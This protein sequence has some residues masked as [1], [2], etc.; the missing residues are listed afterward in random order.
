[1]SWPRS[2]SCRRCCTPSSSASE[3]TVL[4]L[5][6]RRQPPRL[7]RGA[8]AASGTLPLAGCGAAVP[9]WL[10]DL[11]VPESVAAELGPRLPRDLAA[12]R[13]PCATPACSAGWRRSAS[14]SSPPAP[15]PGRSGGSSCS[16]R[17][18]ATRSRC[19]AATSAS[20]PACSRSRPTRRSSRPCS[21]TRSATSTPA[22]P[23][24]G[25]WP[26][27]RWPWPCASAPRSWR[28]ATPT[29]P[30][31]LV[32]AL[33][34]TAADLGLIR[35][36]SRGQ[37][38]QA[39]ELGLRYMARAGYDPAASIAFWQRMSPWTAATAAVAGLPLDPSCGRAADRAAG[40]A[41]AER[42]QRLSAS[43][44]SSPGPRRPGAGPRSAA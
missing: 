37:E 38:L 3:P 22:T 36:F 4:P 31:D 29:I 17:R 1:M 18:G 40:G 41:A 12:D 35:P 44:E 7:P 6:Q 43:K 11:L 24:S 13:R 42:G 2:R 27:T 19:R 14:G 21:A 16:T 9:D 23:P 8:A 20:S 25:S 26:R 10:A 28:W 39:D 33:G 32:V 34:G 15:R 30:A 5:L